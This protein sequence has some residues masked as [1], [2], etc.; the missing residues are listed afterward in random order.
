MADP[1]DRGM[2]PVPQ[3]D[4]DYATWSILFKAFLTSKDLFDTIESA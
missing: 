3:R 2:R 4:E 1:V